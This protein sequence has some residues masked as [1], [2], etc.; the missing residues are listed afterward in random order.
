V[1]INTVGLKRRS[2]SLEDRTLIKKAFSYLWFS[3]LNTQQAIERIGEEIKNNSYVDHLIEFMNTT[4]RGVTKLSGKGKS[5][6]EI[7]E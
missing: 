2:L 3:D 5:E 7:E 4:R 6:E 1:G